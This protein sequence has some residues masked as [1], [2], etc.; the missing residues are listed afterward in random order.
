MVK[1]H[2]NTHGETEAQIRNFLTFRIIIIILNMFF[3][4]LDTV[5]NICSF[6]LWGFFVALF[7]F[8]SVR[9]KLSEIK[10]N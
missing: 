2:T 10:E 7:F 8:K 5:S 9:G 3:R 4:L 1:T 6:A